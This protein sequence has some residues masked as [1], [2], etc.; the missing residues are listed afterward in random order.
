MFRRND[1]VRS[2]LRL[3]SCL[4]LLTIGAESTLAFYP[5]ANGASGGM[6]VELCAAGEVRQVT[7]D[8]ETGE[9]VPQEQ[10]TATCAFCIMPGFLQAAASMHAPSAVS[11]T[12]LTE[13]APATFHA[14]SPQRARCIRAPPF[15][16]ALI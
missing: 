5:G 10:D 9:P 13:I 4:L 16:D 7:I 6:V 2:W 8:P 15:R 12:Y 11:F 3:V 1:I 14:A